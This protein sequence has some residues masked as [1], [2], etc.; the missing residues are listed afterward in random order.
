MLYSDMGS[1]EM[2]DISALD[3]K[4]IAWPE[5]W[6]VESAADGTISIVPNGDSEPILVA[7][8]GSETEMNT[9]LAGLNELLRT[10]LPASFSLDLC[11]FKTE[12]LGSLKPDGVGHLATH[13]V[14]DVKGHL[15]YFE[16]KKGSLDGAAKGKLFG[17]LLVSPP[18]RACS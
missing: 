9:S 16:L 15:V 14:K 5:D 4:C 13:D 10:K 6:R 17:L 2:N 7:V 18:D 3:V 8:K 11:T 1:T 12:T